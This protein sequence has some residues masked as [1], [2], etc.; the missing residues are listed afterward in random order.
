MGLP[1]LGLEFLGCEDTLSSTHLGLP[2]AQGPELPT[3][4]AQPGFHEGWYGGPQGRVW[5]WTS[6]CSGPRP[7]LLG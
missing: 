7:D 5:V 4:Q 1:W 6:T 2:V 3:Q